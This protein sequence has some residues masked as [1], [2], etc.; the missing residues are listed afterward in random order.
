LFFLYL[1]NLYIVSFIRPCVV[2][3][4]ILFLNFS[5]LNLF[6][7]LFFI[8]NHSLFLCFSFFI[9]VIWIKGTYLSVFC[10]H[11]L[12]HCHSLWHCRCDIY[13]YIYILS[14]T[15]IA[16]LRTF[17]RRRWMRSDLYIQTGIAIVRRLESRAA[18]LAQPELAH[19]SRIFISSIN[20]DIYTYV[21]KRT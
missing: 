9:Y 5:H 2:V 4:V 8:F 10:A 20:C 17:K 15:L 21:Y 13:I 19:P 11:F 7:V 6:I 1:I 12:W 14:K 18:C 3:F 16:L